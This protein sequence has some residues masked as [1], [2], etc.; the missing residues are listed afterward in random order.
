MG[1]LKPD[2]A[3]NEGARRVR[4]LTQRSSYGEIAKRLSVDESAVRLWARGKR[5]PNTELRRRWRDEYGWDDGIWDEAPTR[6]SYTGSDPLTT[7]RC[8]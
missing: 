1:Y 2:D 3:P 5:R 4:T 7:K 8:E 6:D